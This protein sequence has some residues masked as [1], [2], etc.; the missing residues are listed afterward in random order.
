[1]NKFGYSPSK[2]KEVTENFILLLHDRFGAREFDGK[3]V[4]TLLW[5][6]PFKISPR[7]VHDILGK[8]R[9]RFTD[10]P[11]MESRIVKHK[12]Y[13]T[14]KFAS[15]HRYASKSI[16]DTIVGYKKHQDQLVDE[17][18]R[19]PHLEI[20][21]V[22]KQQEDWN[23]EKRERLDYARPFDMHKD[24][25]DSQLDILIEI[26]LKQIQ[27]LPKSLQKKLLQVK[28]TNIERRNRKLK[29]I[30]KLMVDVEKS[31]PEPLRK[32]LKVV[33]LDLISI[34]LEDPEKN[35]TVSR[36]SNTYSKKSRYNKNDISRKVLTVLDALW[37]LDYIEYD[38]GIR[39][40]DDTKK[41]W[42]FNRRSRYR[43]KKKFIESIIDV[44]GI[45]NT[46]IFSVRTKPNLILRERK[47][48]DFLK[49]TVNTDIEFKDNKNTKEMIKDI[50]DYNNLLRRTLIDIPKFPTSGIG[51]RNPNRKITIN[52]ADENHKFV[53]RIFNNGSWKE[54]GRYYG[55]WWQKISSEWR[56]Q[57]RINNKPVIEFDYS[58]M[59]I[60]LLYAMQGIDYWT[61]IDKDPYDLS[62][63]GYVM[64][65]QMRNLL[66]V[67]LL[68]SIN[69]DK[70]KKKDLSIA[71]KA[72]QFEI[73]SN[74]EYYSWTKDY[75]D[76][77][78]LINHFADYHQAIAKHFY[79]GKGIK[80]QY[81]DSMIAE[82]IIKQFTELNIPVLCVHDSFVIQWDKANIGDREDSLDW[83]MQTSF[84]YFAKKLFKI[85]IFPRL[86]EQGGIEYFWNNLLGKKMGKNL[87]KRISITP[88]KDRKYL[89]RSKRF[90]KKIKNQNYIKN[91]YQPE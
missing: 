42:S 12:S 1:M 16:V 80:L 9:V 33:I 13:Q 90:D 56:Q 10:M 59:H 61:E 78:K 74:Y 86:K 73:N 40:V 87:P 60:V 14:H 64:D 5:N 82:K 76:I 57:I 66:K 45:K 26:L 81:L 11:V 89:S 28:D 21:C 25:D 6:E 19:K 83:I 54:G 51:T 47:Y 30:K 67:V 52:F 37:Q 88:I 65:E 84:A 55:G 27:K 91:W 62:A 29:S 34:W 35:I 4:K 23:K 50:C 2:L 38:R 53:R 17:H 32:H 71:K 22:N 31:R 72:V 3:D 24:C 70:G 85:S 49:Q 48:D 79:S 46:H 58:G 7:L 41:S 44:K 69:A 20:Y 75:I 63:Y 43:P 68:A 77:E 36:S 39:N 15:T 18:I 8:Y